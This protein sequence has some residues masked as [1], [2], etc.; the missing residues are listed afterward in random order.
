[1]VKSDIPV[2]TAKGIAEL[3]MRDVSLPQLMRSLL[4]L[5][6]GRLTVERYVELLPNLYGDIALMFNV[7]EQQGLVTIRDRSLSLALPP[8]ATHLNGSTPVVS[9]PMPDRMAAKPPVQSPLNTPLAKHLSDADV[10][11]I[12]SGLLDLFSAKLGYR[13]LDLML[14]LES[15]NSAQSLLATRELARSLFTSAGADWKPAERL[16]A[17]L[18]P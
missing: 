11:I 15:A 3:G 13:S 5:V 12:R 7:L 4:L 6:D 16:Y 8:Q 14:K 17:R 2:K 10:S 9:A 1:M 18:D